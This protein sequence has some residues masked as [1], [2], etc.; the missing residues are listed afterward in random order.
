[1]KHQ[2]EAK[3]DK[4]KKRMREGKQENVQLTQ[5]KVFVNNN[6]SSIQSPASL[7]QKIIPKD[8][9][10]INLKKLSSLLLMTKQY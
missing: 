1:M 2:R 6:L 7:F 5:L 3:R 9:R 4:Q 8:F 10:I